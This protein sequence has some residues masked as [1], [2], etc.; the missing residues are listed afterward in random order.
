MS[1]DESPRRNS[2]RRPNLFAGSTIWIVISAGVLALVLVGLMA[3]SQNVIIPYP[4]F[5]RLVEQQVPADEG[6]TGVKIKL[7]ELYTLIDGRPVDLPVEGTAPPQTLGE[8]SQVV[9]GAERVV[10]SARRFPAKQAGAAN[11]DRGLIVRLVVPLPGADD[12]RTKARSQLL[13][14]LKEVGIEP[15]EPVGYVTITDTAKGKT[16]RYS[17]PTDVIIDSHEI[18]GKV[19]RRPR[20]RRNARERTGRLHHQQRRSRKTSPS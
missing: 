7:D 14:R 18:R 2:E 6:S 15:I 11:D 4:D 1:N 3:S 12:A 16:Y 20:Q 9:V 13:A 17:N 8:L 10:A 5:R 19:T